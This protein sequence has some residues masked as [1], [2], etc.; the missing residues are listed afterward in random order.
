MM[1][2]PYLNFVLKSQ[3]F[4]HLCF[5]PRLR[6]GRQGAASNQPVDGWVRGEGKGGK[7][8]EGRWAPS[9][10]WVVHLRLAEKPVAALVAALAECVIA[11]RYYLTVR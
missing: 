6:V 10:F 5:I 7:G 11:F 3:F 4:D 1:Y 2:D 8:R 9:L